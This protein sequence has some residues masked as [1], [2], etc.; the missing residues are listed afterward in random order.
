MNTALVEAM[1][2]KV[3]LAAMDIYNFEDARTLLNG[4]GIDV[5]PQTD[6]I[7]WRVTGYGGNCSSRGVQNIAI[8]EQDKITFDWSEVNDLLNIIE[9]LS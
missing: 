5:E 8:T 2:R 9:E 6:A 7:A 1:R 4:L 3:Q